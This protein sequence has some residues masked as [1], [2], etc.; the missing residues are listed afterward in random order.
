MRVAVDTT[1]LVA[2]ALTAHPCHVQAWS[3]IGAIEREEFEGIICSLALAETYSILTRLPGGIP[4][5]S[6]AAIVN[7]MQAVFQIVPLRLEMYSL[8]MQRCAA[9]DLTS[10]SLFDALH[11]IAAEQSGA[12]ILLTFDQVDFGCLSAGD[13]PKIVVPRNL[14]TPGR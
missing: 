5:R 8:A 13:L 11:L 4:P 6:A 3:W 1:V 12:D 2:G 9:R 7:R 14:N 10:G